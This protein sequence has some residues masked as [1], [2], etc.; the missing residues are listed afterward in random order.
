[1]GKKKDVYSFSRL[2]YIIEAALEYFVSISVGGVYLAKL[3]QY[4]GLSD[5]LTGIL[6]AF[7]SLGCG[8]Q[9]IAIFLANKR[10]VKRWVTFLHII[11]QALFAF[12][13]LVPLFPLSKTTK[14]VLFI[15]SLLLAQIIHN[16]VNA[17][18]IN[19]Y[20]SLV[21]NDKRGRFTANKE[22]VSL[23]SGMAFSYALGALV[24]YYEGINDIRTAFIFCGIGVFGLMILHSLTLI[25]SKEKPIIPEKEE[26]VGQSVKKLLKNKD[27]F[28]I[29]LVSVLWNVANYATISFMGTYLN[30][31]LAISVT[32]VSLI[33]I[34][35]SFVR[36]LFSRPM[37]KFADKYSFSRMLIVCFSITALAFGINVFTVPSNGKLFYLIYYI[38]YCIAQAGIS[39]ATINLIYDYVE[40]KQ[41]VQALALNQTCGGFA[42][43]LITILMSPLVAYVQKNGNTLF[44][45]SVYAQQVM[46]AFS[47][48]VIILTILYMIF[49]VNK[50][51][52]KEGSV[53]LTGE[54]TEK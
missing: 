15:G 50:I 5:S 36:V 37:G 51:K 20:M 41:C 1:M 54:T 28:K 48:I 47:F 17:P 13:Y 52:R 39:S 14:T 22:M 40:T 31:E 23:I 43:F 33:S 16:V 44:G 35:G 3:S 29:I 45:V 24:D 18:K 4:I 32:I 21:D 2:M 7:V 9:L 6:S 38:L 34:I 42:G 19:W 8:F 25:F 49:V 11:S 30:K 12:I 27:L 53:A 46:S 26:S 10:P